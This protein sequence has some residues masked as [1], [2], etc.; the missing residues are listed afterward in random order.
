MSTSFDERISALIDGE[1]TEFEARRVAAEVSQDPELQKRYQRYVLAGDVIRDELP[2]SF[3][4]GFADRVMA[5]IDE[6]ETLDARHVDDLRAANDSARAESSAAT[7]KKPLAG[8][9]IAASVAVLAL[10]S[11]QT[12][13]GSGQQGVPAM[14]VAKSESAPAPA[15][16]SVAATVRTLPSPVVSAPSASIPSVRE[17]SA[18]PEVT[19]VSASG[20][21]TTGANVLGNVRVDAASSSDEVAGYLST[22]SE[23][24]SR[25]GVMSRIRMIGFDPAVNAGAGN[26][27]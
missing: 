1:L 4:M 14:A 7:W 9:A 8:A 15:P 22:H 23:F 16:V 11:L 26:D 24:A 6:E 17:G 3:D 5:A 13:T 18:M 25:S 10:V 20:N 21:V 2:K 12:L 27:Q 19:T